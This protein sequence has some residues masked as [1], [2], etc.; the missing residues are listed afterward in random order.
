[1]RLLRVAG[2]DN[3]FAICCVCLRQV[4]S[5]HTGLSV[6]CPKQRDC[7]TATANSYNKNFRRYT[8][9]YNVRKKR[10]N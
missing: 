4:N 10:W 7:I 1:M 8:V 2:S 9:Y 5:G 6:M 3:G